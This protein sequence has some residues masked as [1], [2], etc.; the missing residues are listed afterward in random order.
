M[1]HLEKFWP[2]MKKIV[3]DN[4]NETDTI[5]TGIKNQT[6]KNLFEFDRVGGWDFIA[7]WSWP[8]PILR[9]I[10]RCQE[11][12][13]NFFF[14]IQIQ[15]IPFESESKTEFND[16]IRSSIEQVVP[17][18]SK[19]ENR[20]SETEKFSSKTFFSEIQ[21]KP[22]SYESASKAQSNDTISSSIESVV[23][24]LSTFEFD[25]FEGYEHYPV[26]RMYDVRTY[27]HVS[28]GCTT[29]NREEE[30]ILEQG[31]NLRRS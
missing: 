17:I 11:D 29:L 5:W 16:A 13:K 27:K 23:P 18:L 28:G 14:D 22:I 21:M 31:L 4:P 9:K 19:F 10:L 8:K 24:I 26:R 25:N 1:R 3:F 6:Q 7:V 12:V 2:K 30:Q 20:K 15:R